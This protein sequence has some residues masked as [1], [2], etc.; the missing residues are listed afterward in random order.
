MARQAAK[1]EHLDRVV[2]AAVVQLSEQRLQLEQ[3]REQVKAAQ[4]H[5]SDKASGAASQ[6]SLDQLQGARAAARLAVQR[7][8][9]TEQR[10]EAAEQRVLAA[11]QKAVHLRGVL[12]GQRAE[13]KGLEQRYEV[14]SQ[15]AE[16]LQARVDQLTEQLLPREAAAGSTAAAPEPS[17]LPGEATR[18]LP[19]AAPSASR[20][21]AEAAGS[22]H[23]TPVSPSSHATTSPKQA[24]PPGSVSSSRTCSQQS[25][26]LSTASKAAVAAA[27]SAVPSS[28]SA[29]AARTSAQPA[30]A[31]SKAVLSDSSA[32][33]SRHTLATPSIKTSSGAPDTLR[34]SANATSPGQLTRAP[35]VIH[36]SQPL[37]LPQPQQS[38]GTGH[39]KRVKVPHGKKHRSGASQQ[40]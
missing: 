39:S 15:H 30:A 29:G 25:L 16:S 5:A 40:G 1:R 36:A 31:S 22:M 23:S 10:A 27:A 4:S 13:A 35:G 38:G 11:E 8:Q 37:P 34:Y 28:R 6:T 7:Q 12:V 33:S 21:T 19:P 18:G 24:Q 9:E 14:V 32:T 20:H 2:L 17:Q 26:R 3:L